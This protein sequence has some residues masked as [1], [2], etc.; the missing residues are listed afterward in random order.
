MDGTEAGE[1]RGGKQ[2]ARGARS[3]WNRTW[4]GRGGKQL[5]EELGVDGTEAGG[6]G[7]GI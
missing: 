2:L 4:R 6:D 1:D 5:P 7:V 3:G